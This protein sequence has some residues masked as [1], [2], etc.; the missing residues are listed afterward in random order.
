MNGCSLSNLARLHAIHSER[1]HIMRLFDRWRRRSDSTTASPAAFSAA[2]SPAATQAASA[3]DAQHFIVPAGHAA[4]TYGMPV[5]SSVD[6]CAGGTWLVHVGGSL[7][8]DEPEIGLDMI[9]ARVHELIGGPRP[10]VLLNRAPA[11]ITSFLV[12]NDPEMVEHAGI[13]VWTVDAAR[14]AG[15]PRAP[16]LVQRWLRCMYTIGTRGTPLLQI[17]FLSETASP[18][19]RA[20]ATLVS[21]LGL[22]VRVP[23]ARGGVILVEVERPDGVIFSGLVSTRETLVDPPD[24]SACQV[25]EAKDRAEEDGDIGRLQRLEAEERDMLEQKLA[26]AEGAL[27]VSP[28]GQA[29][30]LR[31]LLR[32]V[33]EDGDT[34]RPAL[35]EELLRREVPLLLIVDPNTAGSTL[36]SWPGGI[37]ALPVYP[38]ELG[39]DMSARDLGMERGTFAIAAMSPPELFDCAARQSLVIAMYVFG[40]SGRTYVMLTADVVKALAGGQMPTSLAE[41]QESNRV[42]T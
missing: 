33:V 18:R 3:R 23:D 13:L 25:N 15:A 2:A 12:P 42:S 8:S 39:L 10:R 19:A 24:V 14:L 1:M 4:R 37:Q 31:R 26:P 29:F 5:H 27:R 6:A 11:P 22:E 28:V 40:P 38:D 9:L 34:A 35:Y 16:S 36:R 41:D 21:G 30:R 20:L 7:G 32:A 17:V